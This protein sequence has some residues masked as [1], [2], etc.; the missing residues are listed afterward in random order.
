M[1]EMYNEETDT[2][3]PLVLNYFPFDNSCQVINLKKGTKLLKRVQTP[4]ITK[5]L[6]QIGNII[7]LFSKL[8]L[9]TDCAPITM[10]TLFSHSERYSLKNNNIHITPIT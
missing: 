9:I 8:L 6:L 2:I 4:F 5:E 3:V 1:C 7:N 10:R